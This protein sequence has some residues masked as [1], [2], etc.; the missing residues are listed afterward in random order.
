MPLVAVAAAEAAQTQAWK[1]SEGKSLLHKGPHCVAGSPTSPREFH[2]F[3]SPLYRFP[4]LKFSHSLRRHNGARFMSKKGG[5]FP[6]R[7]VLL[8]TL[9]LRLRS[10]GPDAASPAFISLRPPPDGWG[11]VGGGRL[12]TVV[13]ACPHTCVLAFPFQMTAGGFWK[14]TVYFSERSLV[15]APQGRGESEQRGCSCGQNAL[16]DQVSGPSLPGRLVHPRTMLPTVAAA[17]QM[18]SS[19]PE[20]QPPPPYCQM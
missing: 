11:E 5:V 10:G 16:A 8:V 20:E 9:R 12:S 6:R 4:W 13:R 18:F 2:A 15:R 17:V 14:R 1:R 19:S 3:Y 7:G